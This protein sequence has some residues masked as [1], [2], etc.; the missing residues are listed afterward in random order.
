MATQSVPMRSQS[1]RAAAERRSKIWKQMREHRWGY[2][3]VL[4]WIVLYAIFGI[5]PLALSFYLTFFTYSFVRP[6]DLTFVGVGNWL[7]GFT[8]VLFWQS[9]F[10]IFYNQ[11]IFIAL[12]N[13]LG[14]ATALLLKQVIWGGAI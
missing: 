3:F 2:V 5:Y 1:P 4:P 7:N 9:V 8:D 10:N 11:I 14:L 13:G 12:K 6:E